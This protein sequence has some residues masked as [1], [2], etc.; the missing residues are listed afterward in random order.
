MSR[1]KK[2]PA[3]TDVMYAILKM[4]CPHKHELGAIYARH[5]VWR[6]TVEQFAT[7]MR[8]ETVLN[9]E[10][11]IPG[12]DVRAACPICKQEGRT[13]Y[14]YEQLWEIVEAELRAEGND[15]HSAHRTITL[16]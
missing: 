13:K 8:D 10:Q 14:W 6:F 15:R 4:K 3:S 7:F 11:L 16:Y 1:R 12:R 5:Q 9:P 2:T